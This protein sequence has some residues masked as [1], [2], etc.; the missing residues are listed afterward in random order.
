ME[1][2]AYIRVSTERQAEEGYGLESQK[3]DIDEYCRKHQLIVKE[4]YVDAG[5]SGMEMSKRVE[6][7]RLISDMSKIDVIV[8][9]KLD[10][11]ARDTV[12]A[13]YMIEKIF[14]PKGIC[15]ESV[16]D[17]ARYVTPQ[18]KFQTQVMAAVAEYD[19]NTMML[20]MRG[21]MLERVKRG[22][23]M[24]GGN[25]PFCYSYDRELGILVPIPERA[26]AAR[27]ALE[28]YINGYSD[29]TITQMYHYSCERVTK[30]I[31]TSP[32]NI[33]MIPYK[34]NVYQGKHQPI[35]DV[36]RFELAQEIRKSRRNAKSWISHSTNLLTGLCYCGVCGCAMRYQKWGRGDDAPRKIYCCSRN[37]DL[38]Y[39]PNYNHDC[40]NTTQW[41]ENIEKQV[42]EQMLKISVNLSKYK[43]K[44]KETKLQMMQSQLNREKNKL[45]RLYNLY[46][47][48]NDTVIELI[49][50]SEEEIKRI[51]D[52]IKEESKSA[53]NTQ[54]KEFVYDNIK[55]LADVWDNIDK[56]SKNKILKS[57][58]SKIVIVNDNIE[59]Q[60]KNF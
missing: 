10:R 26:E 32:V 60:L 2:V 21:G 40:D 5:L 17:F 11:L 6:L 24:G 50:Q 37:K 23:W 58:I 25:L 29:A 39:L 54:K 34:G 14:T 52:A 35:F 22:F 43:P 15:V 38:D 13:L 57:I 19:R 28:L 41:A 3:R 31:L 12:D 48:G 44:E 46:S 30:A 7:Q 56:Q 8:V 55:K 1:C 47:E 4:Y 9:Y 59:I 36:D 20:R 33:G 53:R 16:H 45:K 49:K 51:T 27:N 18:D 42:E